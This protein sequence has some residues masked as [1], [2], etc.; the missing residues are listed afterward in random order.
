[1]FV[2]GSPPTIIH[3]PQSIF[4]GIYDN[5][6]LTCAASGSP[7]PTIHWYKDNTLL[8]GEVSPSYIIQSVQL[9]DRGVYHCEAANE[10]GTV[11]SQRAVVNIVGIQQYVVE[12]FVPLGEFEVSTFSQ[13]I[14]Q[15]SKDLV[16]MVIN[17]QS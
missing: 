14:I 13:E 12:L 6:T 10:L 17:I 4:V 15:M 2:S 9:N 8:Q 3:G 11:K 7:Q 16:D 5:V 1:M